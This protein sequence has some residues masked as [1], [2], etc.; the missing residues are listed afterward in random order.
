MNIRINIWIKNILIFKYSNIFVTLCTRT[1]RVMSFKK[2]TRFMRIN[3]YTRIT[4][5]SGNVR[6]TIIA[7]ITTL[8]RIARFTRCENCKIIAK[9]EYVEQISKYSRYVWTVVKVQS[10]FGFVKTTLR[11][12]QRRQ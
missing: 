4:G 5:F 1:T 11:M 6:F 12:S 2:I 10:V 7:R 8:P 9:T 3:I